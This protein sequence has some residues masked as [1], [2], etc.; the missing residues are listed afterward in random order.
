[1][2]SLATIGPADY[3]A[4]SYLVNRLAEVCNEFI[5]MDSIGV[6]TEDPSRDEMRAR[7]DELCKALQKSTPTEFLGRVALHLN[8]FTKWV[9]DPRM[10]RQL[11]FIGEEIFHKCP[12]AVQSSLN[13]EGAYV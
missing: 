1:M 11:E 4:T 13:L 10:L 6:P 5:Q 2:P 7:F 9:K 3:C 8:D 12:V